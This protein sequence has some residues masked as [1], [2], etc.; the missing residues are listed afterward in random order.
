MKFG[1]STRWTT[2][3]PLGQTPRQSE[4]MLELMREDLKEVELVE[5]EP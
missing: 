2:F 3:T 4:E 5:I 1:A